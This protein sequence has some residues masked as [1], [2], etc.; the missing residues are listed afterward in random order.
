MTP[1]KREAEGAIAGPAVWKSFCDEFKAQ[2][3]EEET[4]QAEVHDLS[5][6]AYG[7]YGPSEADLEKTIKTND[8]LRRSA[9]AIRSLQPN[10]R[11]DAWERERGQWIRDGVVPEEQ[12]PN[13]YPGDPI[14]TQ[15]ME[16]RDPSAGPGPQY[17]GVEGEW[18]PE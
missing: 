14:L 15:L 10:E 5:L 18:R 3:R 7:E 11:P 8:R 9:E 1:V 13:K 6:R 12:Y 16:L 4:L 2:A 17:G